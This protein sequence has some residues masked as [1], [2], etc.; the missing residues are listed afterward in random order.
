MSK[1]L[2]KRIRYSLPIVLIFC[3][4]NV[5]VLGFSFNLNLDFVKPIREGFVK[6]TPNAE[7]ASTATTSVIVK[8]SPPHFTVGPEENPTSS[9]T[10][11]INVGGSIG[12][13][14]T[15]VDDEGDSYWVIVCSGNKATSSFASG[16]APSCVGG[17]QL[18]LSSEVASGAG[19]SCTYSNITDP[20]SET[21]VWYAFACDDHL[22]DQR[23]SA[24]N[25][26]V[27]NSGSPFYV[28]HAPHINYVYTSSDNKDPGA[29]VTITAS[30]TDYDHASGNYNVQSLYVCSTNSWTSSGGCAGT[31]F[32]HGS[33]SLPSIASS[34][35]SCNYTIPIPKMHAAYTYY[36]FVKDQYKLPATIGQGNNNNYNVNNVAPTV[37]NV[38]LNSGNNISLNIKGA[39]E[40]IAKASSTS[41]T[42]NNG[43]TDL[44]SATSTVYLSSVSNGHDCSA[45]NNNCYKIGTTYCTVSNCS[46]ASSATAT[47]VCSTTL[48]FYTMPTDAPSA[49]STSSW[50]AGINAKDALGLTGLGLYS[51]LNGVEVLSSA[52]LNVVENAIPYGTVQA[53]TDTGSV[54]ASTTVVNYGN[55][56]IDTA[57]SGT[58]MKKNKVGPET[59]KV[60]YQQHDKNIFTYSAGNTS[61][62]TPDT[63][64]LGIPRPSNATDVT[65]KVY[66]GIKVPAGTPS[67]TFYGTNTFTVVLNKYDNWQYP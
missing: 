48:A 20:G 12:F 5:F 46:G 67:A 33:S 59:I 38:T 66:W 23:C 43:C 32:C 40:I 37:S 9:S 49:A 15:A 61:S 16:V 39:P 44:S 51:T 50:F 2:Q 65:S 4:V 41:V 56:P 13:T 52:A 62:T 17:T 42:D 11:P 34:S 6:L 14:G 21:Q 53:G 30:T 22:G 1:I 3:I 31:E 64:A 36:A 19:A 25:Q 55:T 58:D 54:N 60:G 10:S 18:C 26:G 28:N 29:Q 63:V 8:N 27:G 45:N 57:V 7:A 47:V 35:V 24:L